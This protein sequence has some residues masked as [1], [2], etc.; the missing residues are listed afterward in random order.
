MDGLSIDAR[1]RLGGSVA[2]FTVRDVP[3]IRQPRARENFSPPCCEARGS[4][5]R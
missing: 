3:T 4:T 5:V 2:V 1:R